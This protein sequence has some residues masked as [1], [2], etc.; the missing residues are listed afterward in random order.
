MTFSILYTTQPLLPIF[1][2]EFNVTAT[3]ASLTLSLS[4]GI[5]AIAMLFTASLADKV[6]KKRIMMVSLV[7][8]SIFGLLSAF[9]PNFITLLLFRAMLGAFSA[10]V[11]S[12][13]MAYVGEEFNPKG[14][15]KIMG[16]YISGNSFGGLSGRLLTG[17][18]TDLFSWR[19]AMGLI[20]VLAL[21]LS[22]LFWYML[23]TPNHSEP[24]KVRGLSFQEYKNV[25]R[26]KRLMALIVIAFVLMGSFVTLYNY[27][28]FLLMEPPY[29]FSQT[30]IGFI[31]VVYLCGTFSSVYM[32]KKA[33][34]YGNFPMILV[35]IGMTIGGAFLTLASPFLV[36]LLGISIFTFGFFAAHSIA[37][38][39]V[40]EASGTSKAQ[41][42]AL[43]LFFY[44]LGSSMIGS[45]GGYFW[46]HFHW[47]GVILLVAFLLILAFPLIALA[48]KKTAFTGHHVRS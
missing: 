35:S 30:V 14:I 7:L 1:A 21:L 23:P 16:L 25:F 12:I 19:I 41:A 18:F 46:T 26:N 45:V 36:K 6:G 15:G 33:D 11:P 17:V 22:I 28:G 10:G 27:I 31:F 3:Q 44:Y 43:Y 40:G 20:G 2:K 48:H 9:S 47:I 8:T 38:A 24:K 4:T 34:R 5:L 42:S 13:A 32:G 39:W 37:S 29:N